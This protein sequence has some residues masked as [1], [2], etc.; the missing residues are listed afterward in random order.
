MLVLTKNYN[1]SENFYALFSNKTGQRIFEK[2]WEVDSTLHK[3]LDFELFKTALSDHPET[4][5]K[6][7]L[8]CLATDI[9]SSVKLKKMIENKL[10]ENNDNV[11]SGSLLNKQF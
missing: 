10:E 4:N 1:T 9:Q 5:G 7:L 6:T 11:L 8:E 2:L 3:Q